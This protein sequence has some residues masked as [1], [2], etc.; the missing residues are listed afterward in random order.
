MPHLGVIDGAPGPFGGSHRRDRVGQDGW[1]HPSVPDSGA[2]CEPIRPPRVPSGPAD[3]ATAGTS[4]DR[5][6]AAKDQ[7]V[8][9]G[10]SPTPEQPT[11]ALPRRHEAFPYPAPDAAARTPYQ[12][13][14]AQRSDERRLTTS[15]EPTPPLSEARITGPPRTIAIPFSRLTVRPGGPASPEQPPAVR[16]TSTRDKPTRDKPTHRPAARRP[17]SPGS[18]ARP[19]AGPRFNQRPVVAI[20]RRTASRLAAQ[21]PAREPRLPAARRQQ[22]LERR[23]TTWPQAHRLRR[24]PAPAS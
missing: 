4:G 2:A 9:R 19:P 21:H 23:P 1:V 16:R 3:E 5:A 17:S 11:T 6:P 10:S 8:A 15:D 20:C 14:P 7:Q 18:A 22:H 13:P 12:P 24:G